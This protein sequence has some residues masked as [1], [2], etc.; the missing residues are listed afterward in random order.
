MESNPTEEVQAEAAMTIEANA[1]VCLTDALS[2]MRKAVKTREISVAMT[3]LET[4]IMWLNKDRTNKGE[5][6]PTPTHV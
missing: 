3:E 1:Y 6:K 5:L 4:S 2:L